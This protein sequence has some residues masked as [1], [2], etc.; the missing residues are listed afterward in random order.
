M[1]AEWG[2]DCVAPSGVNLQDTGGCVATLLEIE[3]LLEDGPELPAQ[4]AEWLE[5]P[6]PRLILLLEQMQIPACEHC[7][8]CFLSSITRKAKHCSRECERDETAL[9]S[10]AAPGGLERSAE[11]RGTVPAGAPAAARSE[12]SASRRNEPEFEV[13]WSG[14]GPLPGA[15][16]AAGLGST[17]SGVHFSIGR[18]V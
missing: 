14:V 13:V 8:R 6:L 1:L 12:R 18:R 4:L 15:G 11:L 2:R 9:G 3:S 16:G 5:I 17:L 10:D 7:G